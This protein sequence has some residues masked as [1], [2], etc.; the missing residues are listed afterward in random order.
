[1]ETVSEAR[2]LF[3]LVDR[4]NLMIKI[5]ATPEGL[6]A[7][8]ELIAEGISINV[9][10]IFSLEQYKSASNAYIEGLEQLVAK[11]ADPSKVASVASF[12]VSRLDSVIDER[13]KDVTDPDFRTPAVNA[14][15]KAGIANAKLAYA[16]FKDLVSS[17]RFELLKSK[18]AR[19]QRLLWAS[20]QHQKSRLPGYLLC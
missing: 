13:L 19:P 20:D 6:D 18:G 15:G 17:E 4:K 2:R 11:G 9:T 16:M 1:M 12:F 5:P 10:L 8:R 7:V 14:M 3:G